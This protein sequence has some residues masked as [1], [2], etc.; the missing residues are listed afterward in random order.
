MVRVVRWTVFERDAE[1][2]GYEPI[3]RKT[4]RSLR[5]MEVR[6][7]PNHLFGRADEADEPSCS[8]NQR[9]CCRLRHRASSS[10]T[11]SSKSFSSVTHSG[12]PNTGLHEL[13]LMA[14]VRAGLERLL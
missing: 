4:G 9:L 6:T 14:V 2:S 8:R 12:L 11:C 13:V 5:L 10:P 1:L 3:V 7:S